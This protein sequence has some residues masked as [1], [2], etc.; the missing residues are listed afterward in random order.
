MEAVRLTVITEL[1]GVSRVSN[2]FGLF[3]TI[4]GLSVI[5]G[6]PLA[7]TIDNILMF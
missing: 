7:G 1:V 2:A 6:G 4:A 5:F 3:V